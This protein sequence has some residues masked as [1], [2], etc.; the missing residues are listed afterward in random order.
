[1]EEIKTAK[2]LQSAAS[3]YLKHRENRAKL[4]LIKGLNF[5]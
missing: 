5:W 3:V 2:N 1:M 4:V